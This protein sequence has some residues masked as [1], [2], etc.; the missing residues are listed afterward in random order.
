MW[1]KDMVMPLRNGFSTEFTI[2]INDLTCDPSDVTNCGGEGLAFVIQT[3]GKYANGGVGANIGY[4]SIPT[5]L[6][7][8]FDTNT[9][10]ATSD[11]TTSK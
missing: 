6:A 8:E 11:P 5:L 2:K 7:V 3:G 10:S 1:F 9:N 4:G